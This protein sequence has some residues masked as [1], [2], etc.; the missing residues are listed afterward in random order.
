MISRAGQ[1][2]GLT[3][4]HGADHLLILRLADGGGGESLECA[5][6]RLYVCVLFDK[7]LHIP[8]LL[9]EVPIANV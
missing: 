5:D 1:D 7:I 3:I 6:L 9:S 4:G 2:V 8:L